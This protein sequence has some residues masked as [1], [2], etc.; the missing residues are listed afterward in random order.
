VRRLVTLPLTLMRDF[1]DLLQRNPDLAVHLAGRHLPTAVDNMQPGHPFVRTLSESPLAPGVAA[2]SIVAV[3][4]R[5]D[6]L[7]LNDGV[8]AYRSAHLEG[9]GSEK[10]VQSSHSL[11]SNPA[12][13]QEV[14]RILREHVDAMR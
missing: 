6:P 4:G 14:R 13:I 11:Q 2:H 12:T 10:I 3:Q 1:R 9:V 5:G 8:V 7:G